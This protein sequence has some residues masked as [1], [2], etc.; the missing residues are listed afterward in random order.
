MDIFRIAGLALLTAILSVTVRAYKPELGIHVAV[1]GSI[2]ILLATITEFTGIAESAHDMMKRFGLDEGIWMLVVKVIGISYITQ[3][4]S[5]ICRD[6]GE[7]TLASKME[8]CGRI[9][10]FSAAMPMFMK[11]GSSLIGLIG[12]IT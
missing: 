4:A 1:S 3:T 2:V 7:N 8:I 6:C 5:D 11:L 10:L 12:N 9:M